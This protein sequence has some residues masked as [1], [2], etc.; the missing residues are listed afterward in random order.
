MSEIVD[1]LLALYEMIELLGAGFLGLF[2]RREVS[3]AESLR[4][5]A[6]SA[7]GVLLLFL[8]VSGVAWTITLLFR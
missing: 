6:S 1:V 5:A 3:G 4:C 7:V 8:I 2:G